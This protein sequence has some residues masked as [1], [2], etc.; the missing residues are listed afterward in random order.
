MQQLENYNCGVYSLMF[1]EMYLNDVDGDRYD[2][3]A[4]VTF[5]RY[6]YLSHL[7]SNSLYQ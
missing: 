2:D 4:A 6:R 3:E 7:L 1:L 5:F